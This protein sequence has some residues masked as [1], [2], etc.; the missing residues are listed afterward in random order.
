MVAFFIR[1]CYP[2]LALLLFNKLD[3]KDSSSSVSWKHGNKSLF[4][5]FQLTVIGR[6][7]ENSF[8]FLEK[9]TRGEDMMFRRLFVAFTIFFVLVAGAS[10]CVSLAF[11]QGFDLG[12]GF[13]GW[14]LFVSFHAVVLMITIAWRFGWIRIP[15]RIIVDLLHL[16]I[17]IFALTFTLAWAMLNWGI[18]V[19]PV[20]VLPVSAVAFLC[21]G[22]YS[23][24]RLEV[25]KNQEK[26]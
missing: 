10:S 18:I 25:W 7:V 17:G 8:L 16:A 23:L 22:L 15:R 20:Y 19:F 11:D 9:E 21:G 3:G 24:P 2:R 1:V 26:T 6:R 14:L 12:F 5:C 4:L 13:W